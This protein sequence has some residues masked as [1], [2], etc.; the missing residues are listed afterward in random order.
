MRVNEK[1]LLEE[2][3]GLRSEESTRERAR[4]AWVTLNRKNF[5]GYESHTPKMPLYPRSPRYAPID[6]TAVCACCSIAS[7]HARIP[8]R[9]LGSNWPISLDHFLGLS[10]VVQTH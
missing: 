9:D 1:T 6:S 2:H 3:H 10:D 7:G 4:K 5:L 8:N